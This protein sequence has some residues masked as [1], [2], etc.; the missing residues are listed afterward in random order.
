MKKC[1]VCN[2]SKY[3]YSSITGV[4]FCRRC[5]FKNDQRSDAK[6]IS[7]KKNTQIPANTKPDKKK[8]ITDEYGFQWYLDDDLKSTEAFIYDRGDS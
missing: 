3:A 6:W 8:V 5:K 2:S 1:P 4:W 7:Y